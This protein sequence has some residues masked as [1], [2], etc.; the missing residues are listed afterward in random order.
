MAIDYSVYSRHKS[1][2]DMMNANEERAMAKRL[3]QAQIAQAEAKGNEFDLDKLGEQVLFKAAQGV[4]LSPQEQAIGRAYDAKRNQVYTD[5]AGNVV[6]KPP[7][8]GGLNNS[9][10]ENPQP[11]PLSGMFGGQQSVEP[12]PLPQGGADPMMEW[13]NAVGGMPEVS[14]ATNPNDPVQA[15]FEDQLS[16]AGGNPKLQQAIRESY[17]KSKL[18]KAMKDQTFTEDQAKAAGFADRMSISDPS[19]INN[20]D[21]GMSMMEGVS[22]R[23]P[24]IGNYLVSDEF[25]KFDQARRDFI[26]AQLRRESGAVISP[27]EF[28]N[29]NKQYFPQPGDSEAVLNQKAINRKTA[30]DSMMRSAGPAYKP[31]EPVN[32]PKRGDAVDGYIFMGGDPAQQSNWKKK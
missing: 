16:K 20:K 2:S 11:I 15:T 4:P 19:I 18:E 24:L 30:I 21:A 13:Q 3:Q 29:A 1:L 32:V 10:E 23:T 5:A 7:A 9:I 22:S 6:S 12:M 31:K 8:F 28:A 27:E 25:Q 17:S 14:P 26:N